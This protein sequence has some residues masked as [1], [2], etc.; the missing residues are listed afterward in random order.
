MNENL[1]GYSEGFGNIPKFPGGL[2]IPLIR[3]KRKDGTSVGMHAVEGYYYIENGKPPVRQIREYDV[4]NDEEAI[5]RAREDGLTGVI[6]VERY[7]TEFE[8]CTLLN[9]IGR[10]W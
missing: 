2:V 1:M 9:K 8:P 4:K 3:A 6:M 10:N 7:L 5:Q